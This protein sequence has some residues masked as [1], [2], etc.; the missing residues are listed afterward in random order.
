M[1]SVR[2][3]NKRG[4]MENREAGCERERF[5]WPEDRKTAAEGRNTQ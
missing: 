3:E 5:Q 4:R 2:E 1:R